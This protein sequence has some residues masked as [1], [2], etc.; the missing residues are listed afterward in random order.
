MKQGS[1]VATFDNS[2]EPI[3]AQVLSYEWLLKEGLRELFDEISPVISFNRDLELY[4]GDYYFGEENY[5]ES[6]CRKH[7]KTFSSPLWIRLKLVNKEIGEISEQDVFMGDFPLLTDNG[8]FI[9]RG[10]ERVINS[11]QIFSPG[12]YCN[13]TR[14]SLRKQTLTVAKL[15]PES[16]HSL[17]IA[18]SRHG[19]LTAKLGQASRTPFTF[20]I[21]EMGYKND[22]EVIQLF[23]EVDDNPCRSYT[24][25]TIAQEAAI[26]D[27]GVKS[28]IHAHFHNEKSYCLGKIGRYKINRQLGNE[29]P[30]DTWILTDKDI[31]EIV[32][33]VMKLNNG[34]LPLKDVRQLNKWQFYAIGELYQERL[35]EGFCSM[36]QIAEERISSIASDQ[37]TPLSLIDIKPIVTVSRD[38]LG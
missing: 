31:I 19:W 38:L 30:L 28:A 17:E 1:L 24:I 27:R 5:S 12:L 25:S 18:T 3:S 22:E 10:A 4:F 11:Q 16:G 6:Y 36:K 35:L 20:L 34:K 2:S 32:K 29:L 8:T 13:V 26:K 33:F 15:I 7:D 23:S 37:I 14:D 21:R 9:V